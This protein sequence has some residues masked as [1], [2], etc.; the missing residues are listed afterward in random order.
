[1]PIALW[2]G[3][4][5]PAASGCQLLLDEIPNMD[6]STPAEL[7][8]SQDASTAVPVDAESIDA[9]DATSRDAAPE[10]AA[11]ELD[12]PAADADATLP[13]ADVS[14]PD[15]D[16]SACD[17]AGTR[18][19]FEDRDGDGYGDSRSFT[20]ACAPPD[21]HVSAGEDCNDENVDVNP[22]QTGFFG[23]GYEARGSDQISFDYDCDGDETGREDQAAASSQGCTGGVPTCNGGGYVA[24]S[25]RRRV[26]RP[27]DHCGSTRF[28]SCGIGTLLCNGMETE[29]DEPYSCR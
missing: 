12:G 5:A 2:V 28:L 19:F 24:A 27:N 23:Q 3:T 9:G 10:D 6:A 16:P 29:V 11:P 1:L 25:V 18:V 13:L 21:G 22:G 17:G 4:L 15:A 14:L 26:P 8:A 20:V 7:D